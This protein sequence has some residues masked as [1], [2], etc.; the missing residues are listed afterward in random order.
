MSILSKHFDI[1]IASIDV[2]SLRIHRINEGRPTRMILVYSGIHYDTIAQSPSEP[3][4]TTATNSADFDVKIFESDD[5]II[6]ENAV[7]LC[8][9]LQKRHY[10][11]DTA[12]FSLEC[13]ICGAGVR[14]E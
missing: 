13:G 10:F 5:K 11:T 7:E 4:H 14:G 1:E 2:Q 3:P 12:G 6:I 9:E 8:R